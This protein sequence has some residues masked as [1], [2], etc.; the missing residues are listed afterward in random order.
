MNCRTDVSITAGTCNG[1]GLCVNVCPT[2]ALGVRDKKAV[3][4]SDECMQCDH[5][6]ASCPVGAIRL[7]SIDR[8]LSYQSF[9]EDLRWLPF[10]EFDTAALV[11]LMRSRRSCRNYSSRPV[12]RDILTD[13]VKISITAPSGTN[14]QLWSF[15]ILEDRR[16]VIKLGDR[17]AFFYRRLNRRAASPLLRTVLKWVGRPALANYYRRYYRSVSESLNEWEQQG[18][19]HLF[20]GATCAIIVSSRPGASCPR[21]DAMLASSNILLAAHA[22]GLGSCLIGYAVEAMA[23][24]EGIKDLVGI[25]REDT[26]YAVIGLGYP[27]EQYRWVAGRKHPLI[28]FAP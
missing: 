22:M 9:E 13:L 2:G 10:G 7:V 1:C 20:H 17:V 5:C 4:V 21:E 24:D 28:R 16:A 12:G 8:D 11:R 15:S 18:T 6:A 14:S 25:P 23:R 19:D 27:D 3:V 26:V